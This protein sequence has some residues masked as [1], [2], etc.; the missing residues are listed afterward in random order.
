M[1]EAI[2][3]LE[4]AVR[5]LAEATAGRERRGFSHEDADD[6]A[7]TAATDDAIGFNPLPLLRTLHEHGAVVAVMGQVAGIMHG[8]RELTGDLDL[9]WDGDR[10]QAP[11]LAAGF[12]AAGASLADADGQPVPCHP[13][14][15]SQPKVLFR[16][17]L[18]SGDC[19][20][21]A[22]PWGDLPVTDFLARCHVA[23]AGDGL[24]VRYLDRADL[25]RMRR[26]I[27]RPKD[28]RRASELE[29]LDR[30]LL[31]GQ[32]PGRGRELGAARSRP[33]LRLGRRPGPA[34]RSRYRRAGRGDSRQHRPRCAGPAG[35][36][37]RLEAAASR[38][39]P[40]GRLSL[41]GRT[42]RKEAAMAPR[43]NSELLLVGSLPADSAGSA[44]RTAAGLFGDLVFALPD[45]ETGPR[46]AWVGYERERLVRPNPD[47]VV[48]QETE[49]PTGIPR[50]AYETPVFGIRPG[51]TELHWDSW[52]RIDDAIAG[53]QVFS[54]LRQEGVIPAQLRFQVG[55]PFPSS[56]LNGF[57][58]DFAADYPVADRAFEDLVGREL[59]RLSE[60]VPPADLAIQWDLAYETQDLERV[61]AWTPEGAWERFAGPVTRLTR[62]I[63][64]DVLVGYH[65]C[66]GTFPE[67]PMYEARDMALLV[68]MANFAV[69]SSGRPVDWLHLAGPRYLRSEDRSFFRPLADLEP[70]D[71]RVFLGIVLPIDGAAGLRRR[72]ATA[73]RYLADFGVAM[74]CGFG[75]QP[76]ADGT[77]TMR[78]HAAVVRAVR[79][80]R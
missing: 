5:R 60:A 59:R 1:S 41:M 68:R 19:C 71:A 78:E 57:K 58:A 77:E 43:V 9:L 24:V 44:L 55:L 54:A 8:S 22:L 75:R 80:A 45:G 29:R 26:A 17:A 14:A 38:T 21:P 72:Q 66:Y 4:E 7:G 52:P 70:G 64:E 20:T 12:A 3:R 30:G 46:A 16:S 74:Y 48:V 32:L 31:A 67:W 50:H 62:L 56:A 73:S 69:A 34:A 61:L 10:G 42:R 35:R 40:P 36:H 13:A 79:G 53:Y 39:P 11:A 28:L 49:S 47:V 63:P 18:A 2:G 37:P 65:L 15:F 23:A 33:A 6:V 27:G 76:G 25:I 51:V